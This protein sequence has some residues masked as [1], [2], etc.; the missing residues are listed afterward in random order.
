[1]SCDEDPALTPSNYR[2]AVLA[3]LLA[4][5]ACE[6]FQDNATHFAYV[7]EDAT[8]DLRN[9]RRTVDTV[10]YDRIHGRDQPYDLTVSNDVILIT[11]DLCKPPR[12]CGRE[13][14]FM[15]NTSYHRNFLSVRGTFSLHRERGLVRVILA[16]GPK[17]IEVIDVR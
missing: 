12:E 13:R 16:K 17:G 4:A 1:M 5:G 2:R 6:L 10:Y 8:K 3:L 14:Y 7:L 15:S 11:E 9:S